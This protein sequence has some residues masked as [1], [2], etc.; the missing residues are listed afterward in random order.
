MVCIGK[1]NTHSIGQGIHKVQNETRVLDSRLVIPK[2]TQP[3]AIWL[4]LRQVAAP[5]QGGQKAGKGVGY[6]GQS[7]MHVSH[8]L[9]QHNIQP[10]EG[11]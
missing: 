1:W 4:A 11:L 3:Y 5:R 9:D 6:I 10:D 2:T 8:L 7:K